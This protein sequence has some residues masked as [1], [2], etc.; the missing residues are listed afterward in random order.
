MT[1][2]VA[3]LLAEAKE[4]LGRAPHAPPL[5]EANLLLAHVLDWQEVSVIAR[6]DAEVDDASAE[7]F[8]ACISRRAGGEPVAYITGQREFYGRLFAVDHRV[9]IPRPETEHLVA[10]ALELELPAAPTV[11]DLG[12]GSGCLAVT[13]AL[14]IAGARCLATD[15]A[16]GAL[17]VAAGNARRLGAAATV[18]PLRTCWAAGINLQAVDLV[19]SN[20]PYIDPADRDTLSP[21]ITAFEPATALFAAEDGFAAY[22]SLYAELTAL[23]PGT[24]VACE[25]G[26]GQ[27]QTVAALAAAA[28]FEP[29][30]VIPDYAGIE[31]IV[32]VTR[33]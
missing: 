30:E 5:R 16:A 27:A 14:E 3:E 13:L 9:L 20:P 28:G 18:H 25:V 26:A 17:A 11:L 24:P 6:D 7:R 21:E 33:S 23:R 29:R 12:T 19:V 1:R 32:V 15:I 2:S 31:R 10:A 4:R 8:A 22:R